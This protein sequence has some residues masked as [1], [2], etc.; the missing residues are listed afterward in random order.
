MSIRLRQTENLVFRKSLYCFA[1][2]NQYFKRVRQ[3]GLISQLN[4]F[5]HP[6]HWAARSKPPYPVHIDAC[7]IIY[8]NPSPGGEMVVVSLLFMLRVISFVSYIQNNF[9]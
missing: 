7:T 2:G 8:L 4:A 5:V 6:A 3:K 9:G 1:L